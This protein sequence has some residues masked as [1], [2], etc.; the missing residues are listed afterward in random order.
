MRHVG[1]YF[2]VMYVG[3][4]CAC[5]ETMATSRGVGRRCQRSVGSEARMWMFRGRIPGSE[6]EALKREERHMRTR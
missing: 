5:F 3:D 6:V 1:Q 2:V 4:C